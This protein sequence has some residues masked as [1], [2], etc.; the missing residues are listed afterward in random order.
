MDFW[1]VWYHIERKLRRKF[2]RFVRQINWGVP[3]FIIAGFAGFALIGL[4]EA[5]ANEPNWLAWL[6]GEL[7]VGITSFALG[8]RANERYQERRA[9]EA[10]RAFQREMRKRYKRCHG[11]EN[12]SL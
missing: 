1:E 3:F 10:E 6:I 12:L 8:V 4:V 2:R 11:S 7:F 5:A 9:I